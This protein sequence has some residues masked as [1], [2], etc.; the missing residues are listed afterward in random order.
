MLKNVSG[1]QLAK[2][3]AG[4][5]DQPVELLM[6]LNPMHE[7]VR[8]CHHSDGG[9]VNVGIEPGVFLNEQLGQL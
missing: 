8:E 2:T 6:V 1:S 9:L 7:L 4:L 3:N 5:C